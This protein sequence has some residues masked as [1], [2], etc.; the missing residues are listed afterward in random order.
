[1]SNLRSS[2]GNFL[3]IDIKTAYELIGSDKLKIVTQLIRKEKDKKE[4]DKLKVKYLPA[5][6][7]SGTFNNSH[8]ISD[9]K[10]YSGLMQIDVDK[11]QD[12]LKIKEIFINDKYTNSCFISPS[13]I[14][15]KAI[16]KILQDK[17]KHLGFFL[18]LQ[19]YYKTKYDI[20]IDKKCKDISRLMFLCSDPDIFVNDKSETFTQII[21]P[22]TKTT[23]KQIQNANNNYSYHNLIEMVE[24]VIN[25]IKSKQ[26]DITSGYDNWLS[27][28]Y[29]FA[30]EFGEAGRG[31]F[32]AVSRYNSEYDQAK[33][34][35]QFNKCLKYKKGGN[36]SPFFALVI[37][38]GIELSKN[39]IPTKTDRKPTL[40][41]QVSK[42]AKEVPIKE[43]DILTSEIIRDSDNIEDDLSEFDFFIQ[44]GCYYKRSGTGSKSKDIRT[45]NFL[46]DS[47][48]NIH[49]GTNDS[50][51][52]IKLQKRNG[53]ISLAEV[54]SSE[55]KKDTF[56]IILKTNQCSFRGTGFDL[57]AV[58]EY[59][60]DSVYLRIF[61][62]YAYT[63]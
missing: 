8:L 15:V 29:S 25:Q 5:I 21:K 2:F 63:S 39:N 59:L 3:Y 35:E 30:D 32:H 38:N 20:E 49:N 4:R 61:F 7:V 1:M 23:N 51:R 18:A 45:S 46:M 55:T 48:Y 26:I 14:G 34:D 24:F 33:A 28:G 60:M 40:K 9:I 11:I 56:E 41:N 10:E 13:G 22:E 57:S 52:L 54:R 37:K 43:V 44:D 16:V 36:I 6:T 17:E 12:V 19:Q 50:K 42:K 62:K 47:I 58:F 27:V 53:K 31:Y